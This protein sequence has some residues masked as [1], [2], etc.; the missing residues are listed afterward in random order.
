MAANEVYHGFVQTFSRAFGS[1]TITIDVDGA[2]E[3]VPF[4]AE[5]VASGTGTLRSGDEVRVTFV[6]VSSRPLTI[7]SVERVEPATAEV[8]DAMTSSGSEPEFVFETAPERRDTLAHFSKDK[9]I[10]TGARLTF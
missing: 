6:D 7:E 10:Q 2:A 8:A 1:G 5:V 9:Y 3:S 4:V